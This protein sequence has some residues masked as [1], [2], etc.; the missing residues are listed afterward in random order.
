M[1]RRKST[2]AAVQSIDTSALGEYNTSDYCEKQYA[3]VYYALRELQGLSVKHSLGDS[4]SWDELKERFTEV[5]GTIEER[6][7]SLKQ[8][9]EYAGRKFGKS[10]QDLQE[11]NDRSWARRKARSQQQNNVVELPTAAEF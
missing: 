5:F 1:A 3:T 10:L 9:L 7:Y 4:F 8:L 11:I 2:T 6:R